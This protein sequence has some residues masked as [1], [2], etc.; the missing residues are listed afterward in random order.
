MRCKA[1]DGEGWED[2]RS[3]ELV[4]ADDY[5]AT[6]II[7]CPKCKCYIQLHYGEPFIQYFNSKGVEQ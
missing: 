5:S 6:V 2:L 3:S 4:Y 7:R 1:C